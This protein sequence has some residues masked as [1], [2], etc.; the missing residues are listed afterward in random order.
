MNVV[1]WVERP[2]VAKQKSIK[3]VKQEVH[4]V[5]LDSKNGNYHLPPAARNLFI[6]RFLDFQKFFIKGFLYYF[7][8]VS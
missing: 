6:K 7:L 2:I 1:E 8:R 5:N 4:D 3:I